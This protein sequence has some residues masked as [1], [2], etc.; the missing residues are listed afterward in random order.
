MANDMYRYDVYDYD[1][2]ILENGTLSE[3]AVIVKAP[4][5]T[6]ISYAI[7]GWAIGG[8]YRIIRV[9]I[10]SEKIDVEVSKDFEEEW[11]KYRVLARKAL[12]DPK[13]VARFFMKLQTQDDV[14][15]E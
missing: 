1:R 10:D 3:V 8:R 5:K 11:D 6:I 2:L 15:E 9:E 12:R 7:N 4:K 14:K 13:A